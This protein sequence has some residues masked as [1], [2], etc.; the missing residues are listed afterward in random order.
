MDNVQDMIRKGRQAPR[1]AHGSP[2][3]SNSQAK[4]TAK[5]VLRIRARYAD[6]VWQKVLAKEYGVSIVLI[7]K[8]VSGRMWKIPEAGF[9]PNKPNSRYGARGNG[10]GGDR[11]WTK[12]R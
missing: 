3:E 9:I 2:G 8:I 10:R 11:R 12:S 4:L 6:G 1:S 5:D 7:Q